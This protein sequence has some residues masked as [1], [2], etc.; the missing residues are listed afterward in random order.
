MRKLLLT[1]ILLTTLSTLT[2]S[3]TEGQYIEETPDGPVIIDVWWTEE[4]AELLAAIIAAESRGESEEGWLAVGCVILNR[5]DSGY[6]GDTLQD[7]I[8]MPNQFCKPYWNYSD[9]IYEAALKCLEGERAFPPGV[10][11]FQKKKL[12]SWYGAEWYTSIGCHNF[13][14]K[15][16]L[17]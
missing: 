12:K 10:I 13:Y 2:A 14:R 4:D 7:V 6:Y 5:L 16:D 15:E 3:A 8:Y 1:T 11:Y 17:N 9:E